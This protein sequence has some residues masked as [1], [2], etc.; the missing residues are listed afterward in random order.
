M[1]DNYIR[2]GRSLNGFGFN[3][4]HRIL[5]LVHYGFQEEHIEINEVGHLWV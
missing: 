2:I 1:K 5:R 3:D 4:T